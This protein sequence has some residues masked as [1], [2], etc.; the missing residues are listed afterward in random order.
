MTDHLAFV[1][2]L[3]YFTKGP[4]LS[5]KQNTVSCS[6]TGQITAWAEHYFSVSSSN[7]RHPRACSPAGLQLMRPAM[8]QAGRPLNLLYEAGSKSII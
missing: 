7:I 3:G 5:W 1:L 6:F 8:E 2:T 4:E